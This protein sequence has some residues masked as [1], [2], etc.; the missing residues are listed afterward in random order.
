MTENAAWGNSEGT[1]VDVAAANS[2][3]LVAK[4]RLHAR[5]VGALPTDPQLAAVEMT[6]ETR[7]LRASRP[8]GRKWKAL[9]GRGACAATRRVWRNGLLVAGRLRFDDPS[10]PYGRCVWARNV[11]HDARVAYW[12]ICAIQRISLPQTNRPAPEGSTCPAE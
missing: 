11:C 3:A 4:S 6:D 1:P 12:L 5:G 7:A 9:D 2:A 8:A 10:A